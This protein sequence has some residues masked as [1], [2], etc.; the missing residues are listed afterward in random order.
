MTTRILLRAPKDPFESVS[1]ER[2]YLANLIGNNSGNLVFLE[3]AHKLLG[4]RDATITPDRFAPHKLG[5]DRINERFDVYVVAL[6][7]AFR[8]RFEPAL[9]RM[10]RVIERLRIPVVVLGVGAQAPASHDTEHL[11]RM[12]PAIEAFMRAV[13]DRSPS[14][15]VRGEFTAEYLR[16]LGFRDVEVIGCPSM[17]FH[18]DRL[19]VERRVPTLTPASPLAI[20]V[21]PYVSAMGPIVMRHV[22]RYPDLRYIAQDLGTLDLLLHGDRRPTAVPP[23]NPTSVTHPLFQQ[24]KVRLYLDPWPWFAAL[25]E[26]DFSFGTRIHGNIAALVAGTPAVVLAHDSRTLEL[27]RYFE[28]PH[29]R[30]DEVGPEV[31][32]ATLYEE[33]DFGPLLRGHA[34]RFRVFTEYLARHRLHHVFEP[35]EDSTVFDRR[36]DAT[37]FP[38]A[39]AYEG[40]GTGARLA[41]ARRRL[42]RRGWNL[43][44]RVAR[45]A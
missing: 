10:T 7:N 14:V 36:M 4:T 9:A 1:A 37:R 20:N 40:S 17:F 18:G 32:A 28:I 24:G 35:G 25:R 11:E 13:L 29:R 43:A 38:P 22:E 42:V 21:S 8:S 23:A 6:A 33:A 3:A 16:G 12:R 19:T 30:M 39:V 34:D 44:R 2:T 45:G 5:A 26:V 31:D 27:A 15:G 41:R